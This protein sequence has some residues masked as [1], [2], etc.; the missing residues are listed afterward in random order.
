VV[1]SNWPHRHYTVL[2]L[3]CGLRPIIC[4]DD[5]PLLYIKKVL[6]VCDILYISKCFFIMIFMWYVWHQ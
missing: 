2:I 4:G 5:G 6:T 1:S 3:I